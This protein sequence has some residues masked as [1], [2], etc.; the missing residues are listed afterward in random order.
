MMEEAE[1]IMSKPF[2][3]VSR[4]ETELYEPNGF[5]QINKVNPDRLK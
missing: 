4:N 3:P 5:L 2:S 1:T